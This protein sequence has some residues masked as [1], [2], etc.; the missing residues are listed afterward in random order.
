MVFNGNAPST[1]GTDWVNGVPSTMIVYY[2][3]GA[4]GFTN[5]WNGFTTVELLP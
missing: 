5:P 2:H 3:P 4:T 1:V